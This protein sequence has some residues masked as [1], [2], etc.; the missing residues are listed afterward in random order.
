MS[1]IELLAKTLL[2]ALIDINDSLKEI[3]EE[4]RRM[5]ETLSSIDISMP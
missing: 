3:K 4:L 2:T 5:N 1:E